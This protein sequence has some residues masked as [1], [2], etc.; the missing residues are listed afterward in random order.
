MQ[1]KTWSFNRRVISLI[2][3]LILVVLVQL[4]VQVI[5]LKHLPNW[6]NVIWGTGY[7]LGFGVAIWLAYE[8][9]I[10]VRKIPASSFQLTDIGRILSNWILFMVVQIGLSTLNQVL[11]HQNQT[12]NNEAII[13]ILRSNHWAL[14]LMGFTAVF[15]SPL[16]EEFIFRGYLLNAF[17]S[18]RTKWWG[19][20]ASG[21]LFSLGHQQ[22]FNVVS[23]LIYAVLGW[24]LAYNYVQTR[25][26]Q[27]AI[28]IHML[29][30]LFAMGVMFLTMG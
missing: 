4:P 25:K 11:Y 12:S 18:A 7:L 10:R 8:A 2:G 30:N 29:N 13:S 23:F 20:L 27:V 15:M 1:E 9:F 14:W 24:L 16:L 17:F 5:A 22:G 19:I 26:I 21:V 6:Q 3:L 28:G